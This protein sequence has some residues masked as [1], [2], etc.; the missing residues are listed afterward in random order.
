MIRFAW[1]ALAVGI[2]ACGSS[3][4]APPVPTPPTS[5]GDPAPQQGCSRTSV[6]LTPLSDLAGGSYEGHA[7][8]LYPGGG[9]AMPGFHLSEGLAR[10]RDVGPLDSS[11]SPLPSGRY[12]FMS[13]GMSNTTQ[14]FSTF[15]PMAD[16]DSS[17]DPRLVVV[18]GAQGG[19]TALEWSSPGCPCWTQ[20]ENRLQA[21]GVTAAQVATAWIKLADRQPTEGWPVHAEKLRDNITRVLQLLPARFPNLKLAYLSSRIYAGY[22]TSTLNPEPYAYQSGFS[23]R[24]TIEAQLRG[25]LRY[26][27]ASPAAPWLA[28]GPYLWAD[29]LTRR[30]DGLTWSCS[31]LQADGTHPSMSG[32]QKVAVRLLDFVRTDPTAREWYLT[33]P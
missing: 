9:N 4:T 25:G 17:R 33:Q 11:G 32:R 2:A 6:G 21:A 27:G 18:D 24:W 16:A 30:S 8:G 14:E 26:D 22:A 12:V 10:A 7:G 19:V 28:W 23:V 3:P 5:P 15:K 1:L 31:E 20:L 29:G 13:I